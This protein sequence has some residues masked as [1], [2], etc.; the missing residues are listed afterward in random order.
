MLPKDHTPS[1]MGKYL[2]HNLRGAM[3]QKTTSTRCECGLLVCTSQEVRTAQGIHVRVNEMMPPPPP[4]WIQRPAS[5]K[6]KPMEAEQRII[7]TVKKIRDAIS[8]CCRPNVWL[9]EVMTGRKMAEVK[10]YEVPAQNASTDV[11]SSL[12][13]IS[14]LKLISYYLICRVERRD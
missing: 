7:P 3:S 5:I 12:C 9:I 2:G 1:T 8:I 11:P 14:H 10:R 13:A 6:V 4:P